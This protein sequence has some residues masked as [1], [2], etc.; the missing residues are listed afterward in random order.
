M[1]EPAH[2]PSI[3]SRRRFPGGRPSAPWAACRRDAPSHR[4]RTL[5]SGSETTARSPRLALHRVHARE[6]DPPIGR[7]AADRS[8]Y[9]VRRA[10]RGVVLG[11]S[12]LRAVGGK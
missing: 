1:P 9:R 7:V 8:W 12:T 2:L 10:T 11:E 3:V 4:A 5:T 6:G